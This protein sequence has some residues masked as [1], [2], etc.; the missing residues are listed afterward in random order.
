[1]TTYAI[2]TS[3]GR[4]LQD[5][6][7]VAELDFGV[8]YLVSGIVYRIGDRYY[9]PGQAADRYLPGGYA[10]AFGQPGMLPAY[11]VGQRLRLT[12]GGLPVYA[13]VVDILGAASYPAG[14][15][16]LC[17]ITDHPSAHDRAAE[18]GA[19][20]TATDVWQVISA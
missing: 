5:F 4:Q 7:E 18:D 13:E 14:Y 10:G 1:M 19:S 17:R 6:C 20:A 3:I 15:L 12:V 2:R 8:R 11:R 16:A 9:T